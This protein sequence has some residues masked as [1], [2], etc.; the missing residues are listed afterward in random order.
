[1]SVINAL[2]FVGQSRTPVILQNEANECGL[3]CLAMI[4]CYHGYRTDLSSLN[5]RALG[6]ARGA[7]LSDLM[8]TASRINLAARPVKADLNELHKLQLPAIL[9]WNFNHYVVVT[10]V[11]QKY[12][13]IHDPARGKLRLKTEEASMCY[14]GIALEL[15]PEAG[16]LAR[17]ERRTISLKHLLGKMQGVTKAITTIIMMA[18]ALEI[19]T[20]AAPLF[21]Q[22]VVDSAILS[23]DHDLLTLLAIGFLLLKFVQVSVSLLRGWVLM[24]ISNQLNLQLQSKL[25]RH[26]TRLPML[27]FERRH[28]GD[29]MSRFDSM[30]AI[31]STLTGSFLTGFMDGLMVIITLSM[32]IFYAASLAIVVVVA[33]VVYAIARLILYRPLRQAQEEEI[34]RGAK[35]QTHFLETTRGMQSIKLFDRQLLRRSQYDSLMVEQFNAGIRVQ[36]LGLIYQ[37]ING[38]TFSVENVLVVWIAGTMILNGEFSV[39]MLFA[40]LAYKQQFISRTTGL[41]ECA[42]DLKMLNLHTSRVADI[43]LSEIEETA[44]N[45]VDLSEKDSLDIKVNNVSFQYSDNENSV[46]SDFNMHIIPGESVALVG[47]SGCGKTTLVKLLLGLLTPDKGEILIGGNS[48]SKLDMTAFRKKVGTVMQDDQLFAGS[49]IENITFF[50]PAPDMELVQQV[51]EMAAIHSDIV[52][53]PLQYHSMI[54]DMG[55][56]LSGGQKQRLL[57]ARALYKKPDILILDEATSHLDIVNEQLVSDAIMQLPLTRIIIAH[58]PETIASCDRIIEMQMQKKSQLYKN[59]ESVQTN[60]KEPRLLG[61]AQDSI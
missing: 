6:T 44:T 11:K 33:A 55:S 14:T 54:G 12:I 49:I 21:L 58:R 4:A 1:M 42:I 57:L 45:L 47:R 50:D 27:W 25:F 37:C 7:R 20:L 31:Q 29:V 39:G 15:L 30:S 24:V 34:T 10:Q 41:I 18:I 22:L 40:F 60:F 51:A 2:D 52:T 56:V 16:F 26:L 43:A 36:R 32:M 13:D 59:S 23:N 28:L 19:F 5:Q 3:A 61:T 53:M 48:L 17:E 8:Q 46:I 35:R 38:L 9:H